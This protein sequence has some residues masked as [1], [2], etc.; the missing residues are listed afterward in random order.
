[1]SA[2]L[3]AQSISMFYVHLVVSC[4]FVETRK[5]VDGDNECKQ[6]LCILGE[7]PGRARGADGIGEG[8]MGRHDEEK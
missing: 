8:P 2:Q 4:T 6:M 5:M 1:M 3:L 7:S